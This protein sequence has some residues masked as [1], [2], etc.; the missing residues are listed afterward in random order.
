MCACPNQRCQQIRLVL[1][2]SNGDGVGR[3]EALSESLTQLFGVPKELVDRAT[4]T[5]GTSGGYKPLIGPTQ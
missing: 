4:M 5:E 3:M 2:L 1:L